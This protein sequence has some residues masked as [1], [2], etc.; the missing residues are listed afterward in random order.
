MLRK[1]M[2]WNLQVIWMGKYTEHCSLCDQDIYINTT[3]DPST[4]AEQFG[5]KFICAEC[6][7]KIRGDS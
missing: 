3:A 4:D 2:I 1:D 5:K 7:E 6:L